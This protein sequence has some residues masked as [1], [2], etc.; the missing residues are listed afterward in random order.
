[1]EVREK[2]L[3]LRLLKFIPFQRE[4]NTTL[5][6]EVIGISMMARV[7]TNWRVL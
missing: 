6:L 7:A 1:V 2:Y 4:T 5:T 3:A